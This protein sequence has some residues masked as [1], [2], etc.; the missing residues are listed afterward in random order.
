[1]RKLPITLKILTY[2]LIMLGIGFASIGIFRQYN[3]KGNSTSGGIKQATEV[4]YTV[5][6][7]FVEGYARARVP[8]TRLWGIVSQDGQVIIPFDYQQVGNYREGRAPVKQNNRWGLAGAG[9]KLY[10]P[11]VYDLIG[12]VRDGR[13]RA[14]HKGKYGFFDQQGCLVIPF[15]YDFAHDFQNHKA[16]VGVQGRTIII[17]LAGRCIGGC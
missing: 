9:G 7:N 14:K 13:A 17:D 1:M 4:S 11:V 6:G 16:R 5:M 15:Q 2:F 8:S 3:G 12:E 10:V